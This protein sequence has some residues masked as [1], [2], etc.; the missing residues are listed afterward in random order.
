[1]TEEQRRLLGAAVLAVLVVLAVVGLLRAQRRRATAQAA[2]LPAPA[3]PPADAGEPI[4]AVDGL[5]VGTTRGE[6]WLAR[7]DAYGLASRAQAT[8]AVH[9][10]G[11][12]LD[13]DGSPPLWIPAADVLGARLDTGL[14]G[15]VVEAGGL[16][17]V[18]WRLGGVPLD[19]GLR[20]RRAE[21]VPA[22]VAAVDT[23]QGDPR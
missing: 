14:A 8:L 7:V 5:F 4:L 22:L 16:V 21:D 10:G 12:R 18:G 2:E 17:V 3:A 20:P 19:S 15:K 9:P 6:D 23:L 11:L 1:M 13:R